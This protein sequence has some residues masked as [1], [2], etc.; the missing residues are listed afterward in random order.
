MSTFNISVGNNLKPQRLEVTD[1]FVTVTNDDVAA[2]LTEATGSIAIQPSDGIVPGQL[3]YNDGANWVGLAAGGVG[4]DVVG[5]LASTVGQLP[6]YANNTGKLISALPNSDMADAVVQITNAKTVLASTGVSLT[7]GANTCVVGTAVF[8]NATAG[9]TNN[10]GLGFGVMNQL[11]T[12]TGNTVVGSGACVLLLSGV[13]NTAVGRSSLGLADNASSRNTAIGASAL[14]ANGE[15]S[16]STAV[17]NN[18]LIDSVADGNT[19]VGSGSSSNIT[20]GANNAALGFNALGNAATTSS[21]NTVMGSG[22][23]AG[24]GIMSDNSAFGSSALAANTTGSDNVAMGAAA[25]AGN[26]TGSDNVAIGSGALANNISVSSNMAIGKNAMRDMNYNAG[27]PQPTLNIAIG[28]GALAAATNSLC[29]RNTVVGYNSLGAATSPGIN[30][31]VVGGESVL[32]AAFTG[33]ANIFI[34]A[35]TV[36][37]FGADNS[38]FNCLIGN[39]FE[40]T[41]GLSHSVGMGNNMFVL[42]SDTI[43]LGS[44]VGIDTGGQSSV[45][46]GR[47]ARINAAVGTPSGNSIVIGS[48]ATIANSCPNGIAIGNAASLAV[49]CGSTV[50]LGALATSGGAS[51][52]CVAVGDGSNV[53]PGAASAT[54]IGSQ[55]SAERAGSLALGAGATTT[56]LNEFSLGSA[57][58]PLRSQITVGAA[59]PAAALPATPTTFIRVTFNGTDLVIP[60]YAAA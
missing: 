14:G 13:N 41:E 30:N 56:S 55:A 48:A 11:A 44:Q 53:G 33:S 18:A 49:N 36:P 9:A 59:G 22:A 35:E 19:S 23:C 58:V 6:V 40:H 34:G 2:N 24:A 12:G 27:G 51:P 46:I 26:T 52:N 60:A 10:T 21:G 50:L 45:A 25:L 47:T 8:Q 16:D 31:V 37:T 28:E 29:A 32:N 3:F 54:A 43:A 15:F 5:P 17:G 20:T 57:G 38:S 1:S 4:G 42:A 39:G 7:P